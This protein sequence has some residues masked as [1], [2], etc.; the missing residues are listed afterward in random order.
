VPF[1]VKDDFIHGNLHVRGLKTTWFGVI[2]STINGTVS[3]RR[4]KND[5]PDGME[6]VHDTIGGDLACFKNQPKPQF[7]DAVEGAPPGYKYSTVGGQILGQC[8]FVRAPH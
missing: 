5:D 4:I 2:R 8:G 6:V 1:S 7:G 3:L